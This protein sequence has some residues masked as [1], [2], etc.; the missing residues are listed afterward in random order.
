MRGLTRVIFPRTVR[1]LPRNIERHSVCLK[2]P[3]GA[4]S[5]A[6]CSRRVARWLCAL[7]GAAA[8]VTT[9]SAQPQAGPTGVST[10]VQQPTPSTS[11]SQIPTD[12]T[13]QLAALQGR[14]IR[15][16]TFRQ[17]DGV[18]G[19]AAGA[20][21]PKPGEQKWRSL[22]AD[23]ELLARNQLRLRENTPFDAA[24]VTEDLQRL[25]RL[26]RFKSVEASG[27]ALSDG[28]IEVIYTVRVQALVSTVDVVGNTSITDQ[29]ITPLIGLIEGAP[30]DISAIE[31]VSR[32]IEA[33]YRDKGF[34]N[35]RVSVDPKQVEDT[36]AVIFQVREGQKLR[37]GRVRFLGNNNITG[38][39]LDGQIKT[40]AAW[41]ISILEPGE[42]DDDVLENDVASIVRYYK[43]RGFIDVRCAPILTPSP[44]NREVLVDFQIEEGPL[45]HVR[46]VKVAYSDS[47]IL[48]QAATKSPGVFTAQQLVGLTEI[49]PGD[50]YR[51][52]EIRRSIDQVRAAYGKLGYADARIGRRELRVPGQPEVDLLYVI[53]EGQQFKTGLIEVVGNTI[54]RDEVVRRHIELQPD[55]PLDATA[56][57]ESEKRIQNL[58]LFS[59]QSGVK[60]AIQPESPD[61]PGYRDVIAEITETNTGEFNFGVS[62]GSDGGVSGIISIA[63]RNFDVTDTPET[64]GEFFSGESFRGG[65]QTFR[66]SLSPGDRQRNFSISLSDPY[67][68]A[69]DF[70]GSASV[71]YNQRLY[72]AYDEQRVGAKFG[73]G[74]SFGSRWKIDVPLRIESIELSEIDADA[75]T[76]YFDDADTTMLASVSFN[77]T[78]STLDQLLFPTK[79]EKIILGVE[80]FGLVGDETFSVLSAEYARYFKIDEDVLGRSTTLLFRTR[81]AYIPGEEDAAPF[82]E[83]HYLGGQNFRGFAH[84]GAS[85]VGRNNNGDLTDDPIGGNWLFFAGAE[86]QQPIFEDVVAGV[87]F[88]D[89]GTV[90]QDVGFDQYRASIG[91]GFR[92]S[93]PALGQVPLAF[94]FGIPIMKEDTDRERLFTFSL[95]IPF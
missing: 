65:G 57:S 1:P 45:Y 12:A 7:A 13:G 62:A 69:S 2:S 4:C 37:V 80:Q 29:E 56:L 83:R 93:I 49:K 30:V 32:R 5:V 71:Y 95:D 3:T 92:L 36:G 43:D 9:V 90:T 46:E 41:L 40:S 67:L 60:L 38:R 21:Q 15:A 79:G 16:I 10:Q 55:R 59:P 68:G 75:P 63:E 51:D 84:R 85:P 82:Y 14:P 72:R 23:L 18:G 66:I 20:G 33:F 88:I 53:E 94:D 78:R 35:V 50:V 44:D 73:V 8:S 28:S 61:E 76:A 58:R 26:G 34:Y 6:G 52:G 17:P 11:Q 87:L 31:R 64:V 47:Q 91:A 39:E 74:K 24:L 25:N 86:Y 81:G 42:L 27:Q 77:L 22:D 54:T 70:S 89:S 48:D 19:G